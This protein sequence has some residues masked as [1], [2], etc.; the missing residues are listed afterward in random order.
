MPKQI[1]N[2]GFV[3]IIPANWTL[4]RVSVLAVCKENGTFPKSW[5]RKNKYLPN[6]IHL[7]HTGRSYDAD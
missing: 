6:Q 3:F 4:F 2:K 7:Q 5:N 1:M